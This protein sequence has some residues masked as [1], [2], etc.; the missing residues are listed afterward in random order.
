MEWARSWSWHEGWDEALGILGEARTRYPTDVGLAVE[1]A[2]THHWAGA[3]ERAWAILATLPAEALRRHDDGSLRQAVLAAVQ[4]PVEVRVNAEP[5][6]LRQAVSARIGGEAARAARL[7]REALAADSTDPATWT[8]WADFLQYE[9]EDYT[10]ARDALLKAGALAGP[11]AA[12]EFRLV[13][14]ESWSGEEEAARRRLETLLGELPAERSADAK[15]PTRAEALTLLGDLH[16]WGGDRVGAQRNYRAALRVE[17]GDSAAVSGLETLDAIARDAIARQEGPRLTTRLAGLADIADYGRL[18]V[19]AGAALIRGPWVLRA[20]AGHRW[21]EGADFAGDLAALSGG[22]GGLEVARW[23]RLGTVRSAVRLGADD[24]TGL[25]TTL[26]AEVRVQ[27]ADGGVVQL[28]WDRGPAYMMLGTLQAGL[29][30]YGEDRFRLQASRR[31]GSVWTAA[32][33]LQLSR[34]HSD[35]PGMVEPTRTWIAGRV[36]RSLAG[37][38]VGGAQLRG[39][40]FSEAV[41]VLGGRRLFWDPESGVS[42]GPYVEIERQVSSDTRL[43]GLV[44]AGAAR[45]D[46]PNLVAP[47]WAPQIEV[48]A[49]IDHRGESFRGGLDLFY[50]QGQFSDYRSWGL[51][52]RFTPWPGRRDGGTP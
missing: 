51:R 19:G 13:K 5:S 44:F 38:I 24:V 21:L 1:T 29:A 23:W 33:D 8:A 10:G 3:P 39:L 16:R 50:L 35:L 14:L 47:V 46:E 32:A 4:A 18:D 28:G 45:L 12:R 20:E 42:A 36:S 30:G 22:Y 48:E 49:G 52:V 17:P 27:L 43:R 26:G 37:G 11:N 25:E 6:L 34:L 2:R 40:S 31:I 7:F 41:P 9:R 15:S